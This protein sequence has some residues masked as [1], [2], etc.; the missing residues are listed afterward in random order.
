M[1]DEILSYRDL[2]DRENVQTLQRGM[3]FRLNAHYSVILM[4][5]RTNAPYKDHISDDGI[6]IEYEGHDEPNT[7]YILD[8]KIL[9]QP[10]KTKHGT[11]TQN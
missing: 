7:K 2:C 9:D 5:R 4:S 1:I 11:V 3:N 10:Y 6:T 8:P